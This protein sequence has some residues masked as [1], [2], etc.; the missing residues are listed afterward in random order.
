MQPTHLSRREHLKMLLAAA[1]L[2][3]APVAAAADTAA[4]TS[5][6][7]HEERIR[8]WREAK[9]GMFVH[10]GLYSLL[11]RDAWAM[12]DEDIPL[13]DYEQL[14]GRFQ[15]QPNAA[16]AWAKLARKSG[17]KYMVMT[18]KHHEGF[19]LFNSRLTDYCATK[20]GPR[21]DL[22]QEYVEAARAEGLRVGLYY[23]LMDWHHPD[24]RIAKED[25]AARK[26]FI[27]YTHG[28][29]RELLTNYGKIDILWYDM[30]VP[31]DAKGW[32]SERMNKMVLEL[33][34]E[35]VVNNRNLV[36]G[37]FSTP[38]QSTQA[39]KGDW[40]SCMTMNDTWGYVTGD[41]NWK[42]P[43]QLIQNLVEC[44]R[45]GGNYLLNIGPTADGSVPE[46]SVRILD[47]VGQ[48]LAKNGPAIYGAD[49]CLFLHGDICGFTR[50]GNTLFT[51]VYF[52][53]GD[54]VTIGG[55]TTKVHKARLLATNQEVAFTQK[56]RQL[57]FSG[58]P[59]QEP[60]T[61]VTVIVA[62]CASEPVQHA[63]SSRVDP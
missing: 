43:N 17:M 41:N 26:R 58:L 11:C 22:V 20:Q 31:L 28:Q 1:A 16:R 37:D 50:K 15:P 54:T 40:E 23:S 38:E 61:P 14:A 57:I 52:W 9:F 42:S 25:E 8:W 36:A 60:D 4:V 29:I 21:R 12:G 62:E 39:T 3:K 56:A 55:V 47:Q 10:W 46:P 59:P 53:P 63:L 27:D 49:K 51:H 6:P 45:D 48:W 32:E 13:S 5:P 24:W 35:I 34:P 30:A 33:Q 44:A 2:A 19:C 7:R 18:A